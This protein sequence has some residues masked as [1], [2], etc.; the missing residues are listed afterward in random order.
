MKTYH[1]LLLLSILSLQLQAT[2]KTQSLKNHAPKEYIELNTIV[3]K[4]TEQNSPVTLGLKK[5][6]ATKPSDK[7]AHTKM[8]LQTKEAFAQKEKAAKAQ[9]IERVK[10]WVQ[11]RQ[12]HSIAKK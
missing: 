6:M 7:K 11:S 8:S 4:Q 9:S 2:Y 12:D 3:F 1:H 10:Q 5:I